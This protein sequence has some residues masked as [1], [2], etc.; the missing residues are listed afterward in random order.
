VTAVDVD[1]AALRR[2]RGECQG[3]E[4][5]AAAETGRAVRLRHHA[6]VADMAADSATA[7]AH[8][9]DADLHDAK[10]A[11]LHADRARVLHAMSGARPAA[12][13]APRG[14]AA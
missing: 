7:Q 11:Q 10:A 2:I 3:M 6:D 12:V 1:D 8:R 14:G 9:H 13:P 4:I 5:D